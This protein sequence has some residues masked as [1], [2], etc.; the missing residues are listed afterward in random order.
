M[1]SEAYHLVAA[2]IGWDRAVDF[3]GRVQSECQSPSHSRGCQRGSI[4]IPHAPIRPD[5]SRSRVLDFLSLQDA[6]A[7]GAV[8]GGSSLVFSHIRR[9]T[10]GLRNRAIVA[11]ARAGAS[12]RL[13]AAGHGIDERQVRRIIASAG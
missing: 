4:Y 7:L 8:M 13:L 9:T 10:L 5:G 6:E 1:L 3:G 12:S 11:Q 2:V